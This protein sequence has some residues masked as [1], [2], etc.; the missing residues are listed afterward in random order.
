MS[1]TFRHSPCTLAWLAFPAFVA[2]FAA[3]AQIATP[4]PDPVL[5]ID[6]TGEEPEKERGV[7]IGFF[8]A[9]TPVF[10]GSNDYQL[11]AGPNL[12]V[13]YDRAF[14]SVQDGLGYDVIRSGGWS[15]GPTVGFRQGRRENGKSTFTIA[16]DRSDA[17]RGLGDVDDVAEAGGYV[18]YQSGNFAAKLD[19]RQ[20]LS[21]GQG[22]IATLG[23]VYVATIPLASTSNSQPIRIS[24]GPRLSVV[25]DKYNQTYFG[26]TA[27]QSARSGLDQFDANGGLLSAGVGLS[28]HIPLAERISGA[29]L[30]GYERLTG[31][32]ARAPLVEDRGSQNQATVGLGLTY[33]FGL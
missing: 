29:I 5:L 11:I 33:R 2:P 4:T 22:L 30:M 21:G 16:G 1:Y 31:D 26:V 15:A 6:R 12:Q 23:L 24:I 20:A 17:L 9:Y 3:H 19:I 8:S 10:L 14:F 7:E 32:A 13:R 27:I 25:D 28:A 18:G